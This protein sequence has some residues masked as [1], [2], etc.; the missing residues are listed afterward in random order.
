M[1]DP[2]AP[3]PIMPTKPLRNDG[4]GQDN[5]N[6]ERVVTQSDDDEELSLK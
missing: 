5:L 1:Q 3:N 4:S 2:Y 6:A